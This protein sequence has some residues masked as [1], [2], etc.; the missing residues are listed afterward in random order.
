MKRLLDII[1]FTIG[2]GMLVFTVML[3]GGCV[4]PKPRP[5]AMPPM[6]PQRS[7]TREE[8]A[9]AAAIPLPPLKTNVLLVWEH[10]NEYP[11]AVVEFD[12]ERT[13]NF[14]T[15]TRV[16]RTTNLT[17]TIPMA[18]NAIGYYRVGAHYK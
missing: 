13:F 17:A 2:I 11:F 4:Q 16:A 3:A 5:M 10:K 15:W 14:K 9:E 6:P 12:V 18:G 7:L 1:V 8:I